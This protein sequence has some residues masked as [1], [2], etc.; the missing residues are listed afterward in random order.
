MSKYQPTDTPVDHATCMH[1]D[2]VLC[3]DWSD[4]DIVVEESFEIECGECASVV[5]LTVAPFGDLR[6]VVPTVT[7]QTFSARAPSANP[8]KNE[9]YRNHW[10][11]ELQAVADGGERPAWL[12]VEIRML[13]H[14]TGDAIDGGTVVE[15]LVDNEGDGGFLDWLVG[16][17]KS[18]STRGTFE[19]HG[20]A[21]VYEKVGEHVFSGVTV[22]DRGNG[23]FEEVQA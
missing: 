5:V 19:R 6:G 13:D 9:F 18:G 14:E 10:R 22:A 11:A 8:L 16:L 7:S 15:W 3:D 4:P 2:S 12:D 23:T 20:A 1:C 21:T 17:A